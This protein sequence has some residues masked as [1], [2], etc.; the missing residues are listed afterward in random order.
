MGNSITWPCSKQ[1]DLSFADALR[2]TCILI[3]EMQL[4]SVYHVRYG[5]GGV[6][7]PG[8]FLNFKLLRGH[9]VLFPSFPPS[10]HYCAPCCI[11][12]SAVILIAEGVSVHI[13]V[14]AAMT[15]VSR[16]GELNP[17]WK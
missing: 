15:G 9:L 1:W 10:L 7:L 17:T 14:E 2:S 16:F 3:S 8:N 12:H 11:H 4:R 13:G 6:S 5:T